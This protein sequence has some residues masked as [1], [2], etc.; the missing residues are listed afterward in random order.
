MFV[1]LVADGTNASAAQ[2][3]FPASFDPILH[4]SSSQ[5]P[6]IVPDLALASQ[7]LRGLAFLINQSK[8]IM[9]GSI[10]MTYVTYLGNIG[11]LHILLTDPP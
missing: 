5:F 8:I 3:P 2:S 11:Y 4:I 9:V 10:E 1:W 7:R 6:R